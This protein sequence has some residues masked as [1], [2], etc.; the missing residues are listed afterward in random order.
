MSYKITLLEPEELDCQIKFKTRKG[1]KLEDREEV[2]KIQ[3]KKDQTVKWEATNPNNL[4]FV[5]GGLE[6]ILNEKHKISKSNMRSIIELYSQNFKK[7]KELNN[8]YPY[9]LQTDDNKEVF[10]EGRCLYLFKDYIKKNIFSRIKY[11]FLQDTIVKTE[12]KEDFNLAF[13]FEIINFVNQKLDRKY[14]QLEMKII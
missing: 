11:H 8:S 10:V 1:D 12:S 2:K 7:I 5:W 13:E 14:R 9:Y 6:D 3:L 4:L